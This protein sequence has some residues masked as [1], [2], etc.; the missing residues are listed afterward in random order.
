[1]SVSGDAPTAGGPG[2]GGRGQGDTLIAPRRRPP[3]I[4]KG[5]GES[6]F[7]AVASRARRFIDPK[8]C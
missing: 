7:A 2:W 5:G 6:S 8:N 1:M 3:S 4:A